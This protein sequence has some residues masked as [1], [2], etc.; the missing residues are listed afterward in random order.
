VGAS[1]GGRNPAVGAAAA[2]LTSTPARRFR[3]LPSIVARRLCTACCWG[4]RCCRLLMRTRLL[5]SRQLSVR[6]GLSGGAGH[7]AC[8]GLKPAE[9]W[10]RRAPGL[11]WRRACAVRQSRCWAALEGLGGPWGHVMRAAHSLWLRGRRLLRSCLRLIRLRCLLRQQ[12]QGPG[13][14]HSRLIPCRAGRQT[15]R[16]LCRSGS[17]SLRGRMLLACAGSCAVLASCCA[18]RCRCCAACVA[19]APA[20][21]ACLGRSCCLAALWRRGCAHQQL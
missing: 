21:A 14:R 13:Q 1:L 20:A 11:P 2:W 10:L 9:L 15:H 5:R 6:Q 4:L 7:A 18:C 17:A 12:W 19:V 16:S 8:H 3:Q